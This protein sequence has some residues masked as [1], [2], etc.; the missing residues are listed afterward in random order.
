[1]LPCHD[2]LP[3]RHSARRS[4]RLRA[5]LLAAAVL[6]GLTVAATAAAAPAGASTH[7]RTRLENRI[8]WAIHAMINRER[9][10]HGV[11]PVS[12]APTLRLSAR[13]HNI[14]MCRFNTMS[15]QLPGEPYFGR[16][17]INAGYHW[18]YAGENLGWNSEMT[19]AGVVLLE[20]LMYHEKAPYNGHR[21]N[22]LS[23]HY[24]NVG[25]DVY[26]DQAHHKVWLTTD[27]G[28]H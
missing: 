10:A 13:R 8:G 25:V 6:L 17:M 14:T 16:R 28:H 22:I 26:M 3:D 2:A 24:K 19:K 27:Y 1:M 12:M 11:A 20:R 9:A 23:R 5:L 21:L 7:P 18:T 15:H 4:G